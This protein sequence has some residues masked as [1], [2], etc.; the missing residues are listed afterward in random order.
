MESVQQIQETPFSIFNK[1]YYK[2]ESAVSYE[3]VKYT[4]RNN[5]IIGITDYVLQSADLDLPLM[6]PDG[7]IEA[8]VSI[9]TLAS[10][11]AVNGIP[12]NNRGQVALNNNA[13]YCLFNRAEL[14]FNDNLV[15][16]IDNN[17]G[18]LQNVISQIEYSKEYAESVCNEGFEQDTG[19][20]NHN[21]IT[22]YNAAHDAACTMKTGADGTRLV[23]TKNGGAAFVA[24][25]RLHFYVS[26][27]DE[28]VNFFMDSG[29]ATNLYRRV[30]P[31]VGVIQDGNNC[32]IDFSLPTDAPAAIGAQYS[33][34][35]AYAGETEIF[36]NCNGFK[37]TLSYPI[38][39]DGNTVFRIQGTNPVP[40]P[41]SIIYLNTPPEHPAYNKGFEDRRKL[42]LSADGFTTGKFAKL[43]IPL[44]K[45][46]RLF[47]WNQHVF[48]GLKHTIR[49]YK[50]QNY[51]TVLLKDDL[52]PD[53]GVRIQKIDLWVPIVKPSPTYAL[54]L[55]QALNSGAKTQLLFHD[56]KII[57]SGEYRSAEGTA[58]ENIW[59]ITA[60]TS[61]VVRMYF[62]FHLLNQY[63]GPTRGNNFGKF[64]HM[65][66]SN[67]YV[68][69][70]S[71]RY[72]NFEYESNF[73]EENYMR[74]YLAYLQASGKQFD[75]NTGALQC[76]SEF[77][78]SPIFCFLLDHQDPTI[79]A[80]LSNQVE[81]EFHY[82]RSAELA[83]PENVNYRIYCIL[84]SERYITLQGVDNR[85]RLIQ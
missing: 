1:T 34:I 66:V 76:Y 42:T 54:A 57:Q 32:P 30:I 27:T 67:S 14:Y 73:N 25:Q 2:D 44:R 51:K 12:V 39:G 63:S 75:M 65:N 78:N 11:D 69:L 80:G 24:A 79:W 37:C 52:C 71:V 6:M 15:E 43:I 68:L 17:S 3:Y 59:R 56:L 83:A 28:E 22:I 55:D 40:A 62:V 72:P 60:S 10:V 49:L 20:L 77:K 18:V 4:E 46:F 29:T 7:F 16:S 36:F 48:R 13:A 84:E 41:D 5:N 21:S 64:Q 19:A 81:L 33:S 45:L 85:M 53:V 31:I 23:V 8:E 26:D 70:N 50:N 74:L 58:G 61:K 35:R 38:I 47:Q 9:S 82:R